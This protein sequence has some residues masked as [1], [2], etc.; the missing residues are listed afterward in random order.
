MRLARPGAL[1][2]AL[3]ACAGL[4][5]PAARAGSTPHGRSGVVIV[6]LELGYQGARAAGTGMV[7]TSTGEVL[8]NNHVI[9]QATAIRVKVPRRTAATPRRS[10]ATTS[11]ATPRS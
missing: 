1:F 6:D 3:V 10:S 7:L 2:A 9:A 5:T 8:T 4:A 11:P